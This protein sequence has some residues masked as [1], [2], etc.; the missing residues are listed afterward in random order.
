MYPACS[1]HAH[2]VG[3][4]ADFAG[5]PKPA[6]DTV[7]GTDTATPPPAAVPRPG[8]LGNPTAPGKK[9]TIMARTGKIARLPQ[10]VRDEINRR[11]AD[12][13]KATPILHWI[14]SQPEVAE[15][16]KADFKGLPVT[17]GNLADW[18]AGGFKDWQITRLNPALAEP[19]FQAPE[20]IVSAAHERSVARMAV[21]FASSLMEDLKRLP[22]IEDGAERAALWRE[23]RLGLTAIR[24]YEYYTA[25]S[26]EKRAKAGSLD[27]MKANAPKPLSAEERERRAA[28]ILGLDPDRPRFDRETQTWS[29]PNADALNEQHKRLLQEHPELARRSQQNQTKSG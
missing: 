1:A 27:E 4:L 7:P 28:H 22:N 8:R 3:W 12:G 21:L 24:T 15:I 29:G 17:D 11:L 25:L 26:K 20:E 13:Q 2:V 18:R 23:L 16:L 5:R 9:D 6:P 14:N 19:V 10:A